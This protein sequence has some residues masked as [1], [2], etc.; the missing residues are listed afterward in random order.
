MKQKKEKHLVNP[1]R[2]Y[3]IQ[4]LEDLGG[5]TNDLTLI[6]C[7]CGLVHD[8]WFKVKNEK[9]YFKI[10]RN[11]YETEYWRKYGKLPDRRKKRGIFK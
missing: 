6:C 1:D 10:D 7:D 8:V 5:K 4:K 3:V 2:F 9:L 11:E